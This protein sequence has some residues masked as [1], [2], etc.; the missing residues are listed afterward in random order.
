MQRNDA[1][2]VGAGWPAEWRIGPKARGIACPLCLPVFDMSRT[3][4]NRHLSSE[5]FPPAQAGRLRRRDEDVQ[6]QHG[7]AMNIEAYVDE[8]TSR[9]RRAARVLAVAGSAQKDEALALIAE[10]LV[11]DT[12]M[13]QAE[14]KKDL[15]AAKNAGLSDALVDRLTLD[16]KRIG[17]MA[18]AV[19]QIIG[20]PDPVGEV[21]DGWVRPNGL[22]LHRVR[23]PIG[24]VAM[25]YESRPNVTVDAG[26]L[27]LKSGNASILRGGKES[28]N[29]NL[30]IY[31]VIAE[32]MEKAGLDR[33]CI[34]LVETTDR[35]VVARLLKAQG[36]VDV[37]IPRG[38]KGLIKAVV[39]NS[40]IPVIKHYEGVCHVYV[41]EGADLEMARKICF[42]AKV[43]RPGVCNAMETMLVHEGVAGEFLPK[44]ITDLQAA[45]C[46]IRGCATTRRIAPAVTAEAT[47]EDWRAEYLDLIL[48]V[49]VVNDLDEAID[50]IN[51]YG[52]QHTDSIVTQDV[53]R[54]EKFVAQ[55]DSACVFVNC[56]TRFSDGGEFG[57]GAE[58]GISTERLHA[59]GPMGL[60]ELTSYK[61][62]AHGNGQLRT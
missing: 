35:E 31:K 24:V 54:A 56:S 34:Q 12:E 47:E 43:Q 42:N 9:A 6:P 53:A 26:A 7:E 5:R 51:D 28:L 27:C 30:A 59:R 10:G 13:L 41:D 60:R 20:L 8:L 22:R 23:V 11:A 58:I 62:V 21:I 16:G 49:R 44:I 37:V 55:V 17:K 2:A 19:K 39:E 61:W 15:D 25:I 14:N 38:G 52:S 32:A 29:S 46:E 4:L 50:H 40:T 57:L 36:K 18:D 45:D 33:N 3:T 48:A 1:S